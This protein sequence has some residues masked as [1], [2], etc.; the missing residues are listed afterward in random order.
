MIRHGFVQLMRLVQ[1]MRIGVAALWL[2]LLCGCAATFSAEVTRYQQWP[3]DAGGAAYH[4]VATEQDR[5]NLQFQTYSDMLRAAIGVTGLVEASQADDARFDVRM[6]YGSPATRAWVSRP[7]DP[8][9]YS[10]GFYGFG[11]PYFGMYRP[12]GGWAFG[13]PV[14]NVPVDLYR[15]TLTVTIQDRQRAGHEVYR[16][17][18]VSLGQSDNLT[19]VMPYLA[20]AIFDGFPGRHAQ[21]IEVRYPLGG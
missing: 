17:S 14:E 21:V 13:P 6:E 8:F 15:H 7:V 19:V 9:Y 10:G 3:A 2:A 5:Q 18:A 16:A 20:R 11:G 4:I 12:W 1:M